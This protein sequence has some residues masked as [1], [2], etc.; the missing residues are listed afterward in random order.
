MQNEKIIKITNPI[1]Q[2]MCKEAATALET[3]GTVTEIVNDTLNEIKRQMLV[4]L[5]EELIDKQY[6][7][8]ELASKIR[9]L[10][11]SQDNGNSPVIVEI[12][13]KEQIQ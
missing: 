7:Q 6:L 9:G 4:A 2:T 12:V 8:R 10:M 13:T 3:L 5:A 1:H 11:I